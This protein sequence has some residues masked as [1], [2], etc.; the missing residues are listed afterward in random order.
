[1]D[2]DTIAKAENEDGQEDPNKHNKNAASLEQANKIDS[3]TKI[4][5]GID[6]NDIKKYD[7]VSYA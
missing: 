6:K 5:D 2:N 7:K 4:K 1:M 3:P